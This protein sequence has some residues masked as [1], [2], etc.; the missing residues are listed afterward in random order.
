[1]LSLQPGNKLPAGVGQTSQIVQTLP[2]WKHVLQNNIA[3]IFQLGKLCEERLNNFT[4]VLKKNQYLN[5]KLPWLVVLWSSRWW[6]CA[7]LYPKVALVTHKKSWWL[8]LTFVVIAGG[9]V[10]LPNVT[11][12]PLLSYLPALRR[13]QPG[14]NK[15]GNLSQNATSD[16]R[17]KGFILWVL[18]VLGHE[19]SP[20]DLVT[21]QTFIYLLNATILK[22]KSWNGVGVGLCLF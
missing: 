4:L 7:S 19:I 5:V 3:L 14:Q 17:L 1:M 12:I 20:K 15:T 11:G 8:P 6:N 18:L 2:S 22:E 21:D 10:A 16:L 13:H 9:S